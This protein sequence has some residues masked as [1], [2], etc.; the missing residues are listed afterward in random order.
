MKE[1]FNLTYLGLFPLGRSPSGKDMG[2]KMKKFLLTGII[3]L[4]GTLFG[5]S[6]NHD[7]TDSNDGLLIQN[8]ISS[9]EESSLI[10]NVLNAEGENQ[11][12]DSNIISAEELA[13]SFGILILL[14]ENSSWIADEEYC[15]VDENNLKIA[16]HD[17]IADTDCTLLVSKNNNLNLPQ[18]EYDETLNES[19]EG[20]TISSQNIVV[21]VQ[22]KGNDEKMVLA[23]WE[24]N[25][26][27]FAII[28]EDKNDSNSIPKVA[29]NIIKNL[30]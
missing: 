26:Y 9:T 13:D 5:C 27:Q 10:D 18:N 30:D 25:E 28:G 24:Y 20:K 23:T 22:N 4:C 12:E 29:L 21:K 17:F 7:M 19:W 3:C 1:T 15:L 16:Y 2:I 8:S 11:T 6:N 14:P